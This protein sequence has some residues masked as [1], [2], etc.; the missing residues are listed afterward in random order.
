MD[1]TS[2]N[3]FHLESEQGTQL[4]GGNGKNTVKEKSLNPFHLESEQGT[5]F[6][7]FIKA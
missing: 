2:L 3:P 4:L 6:L 1:L 5:L 7:G